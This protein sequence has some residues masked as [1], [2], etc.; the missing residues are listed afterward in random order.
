MPKQ[1]SQIGDGLLVADAACRQGGS[2]AHDSASGSQQA[3][4]I[5]VPTALV[6]CPHDSQQ[7]ILGDRSKDSGIV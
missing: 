6:L 1:I 2:F 3:A 4:E 7:E 5:V